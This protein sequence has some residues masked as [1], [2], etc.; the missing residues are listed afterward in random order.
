MDVEERLVPLAFLL[1]ERKKRQ[2]A[3]KRV[4]ELE[5]VLRTKR[6]E[7]IFRRRV[8]RRTN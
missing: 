7:W 3:E 4:E 5:A 6:E 8:T 2:A 1:A